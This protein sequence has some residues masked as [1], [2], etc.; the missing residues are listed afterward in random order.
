MV[1]DVTS[2][3]EEHPG[4]DE[5]IIMASGKDATADFENVGHS[6]D[7]REKLKELYIGDIDES[8]LPVKQQFAPPP[9]PPAPKQHEESGNSSKVLLYILP[10]F[11]FGVAFLFRFYSKSE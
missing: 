5:V 7:A 2:F 4:G 8:T 11:I 6:S 1:Y 3:L 10:L 9:P